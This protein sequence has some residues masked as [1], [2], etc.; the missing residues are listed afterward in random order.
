MKGTLGELRHALLFL[1][2]LPLTAPAG[3]A[4]QLGRSMAYFPLIGLGLGLLLA[5]ADYLLL[6]FFPPAVGALLVLLLLIYATGALHL[7]GVADTSDGMYGIR[8]QIGRA[9][10]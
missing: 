4:Q 3:S 8:D 10:V 6:I 7:D 9:H 5:G 2:I 1:T